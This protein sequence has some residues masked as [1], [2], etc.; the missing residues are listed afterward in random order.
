M[1]TLQQETWAAHQG[2][3]GEKNHQ[4]RISASIAK[5]IRTHYA[6]GAND[7]T[8]AALYKVSRG[9]CWDIGSGRTWTHI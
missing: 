1:S 3:P 6:A 2:A 9:T 8:I 7:A 4:A 5:R